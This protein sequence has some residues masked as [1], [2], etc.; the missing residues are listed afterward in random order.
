MRKLVVPLMISISVLS[1]GV[2]NAMSSE[3]WIREALRDPIVSSLAQALSTANIK[4]KEAGFK[5][6]ESAIS[7]RQKNKVWVIEYG[8]KDKNILGGT[9]VIEVDHQGKIQDIERGQ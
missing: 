8:P 6:D 1:L 9:L 5:L 2:S 3:E 4:A 7:I